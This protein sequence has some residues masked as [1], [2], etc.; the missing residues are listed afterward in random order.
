MKF[1]I[2]KARYFLRIDSIFA[3]L[4]FGPHL[5]F[6]GCGLVLLFF[7]LDHT[8]SPETVVQFPIS[9]FWTTRALQRLWSNSAYL[10][11]RPHELYGNCGPVSRI[12]F[13]D[14]TN[15][16]AAVVQFL[17]SSFWTTQALLKV[18]YNLFI[19]PVPGSWHF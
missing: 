17:I 7:V 3:Y 4:L 15:F 5:L 10:L 11:S 18:M 13:L 2:E 16:P 8:S 12:F 6:G 14:H 19:L 1:L 9:S